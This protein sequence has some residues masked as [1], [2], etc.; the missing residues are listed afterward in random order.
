MFGFTGMVSSFSP[1]QK[2]TLKKVEER[3][4]LLE[5]DAPYF[6]GRKGPNFSILLGEVATL[7]AQCRG[8]TVER[9]LELTVANGRRL[10]G[11]VG[12]R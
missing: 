5:T 9:I 8:D 3:R 1:E 7:V 11:L 12:T 4:L 2:E 10:Y 6:G